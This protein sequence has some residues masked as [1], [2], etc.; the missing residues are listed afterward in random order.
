M[1]RLKQAIIV[2]GKYDK[3]KLE[4]V[5][6]AVILTTEGFGIY[7]DREKLSLI[8]AFAERDGI[9]ILTDS[10][11]AGFQI[12]NFL[13]GSIPNGKIYHAYIPDVFG[14]ETRKEK[15]SKEGKLGVEG[16]SPEVL[17]KALEEAGILSDSGSKSVPAVPA[18]WISLADLMD[19]GLCGGSGSSALR[20]A[21]LKQLGLPERLST[22]SLLE[23][24]NR[25]YEPEEY[26]AALCAALACIK[27]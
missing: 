20:K 2:E 24:L 4:S 5:V 18:P 17:A 3:I 8:R 21:L 12:R 13:R 25:L 27:K 19:D 1:L 26:R 15:P 6:D 10:D 7:K 9:V 11:A 14:K 23:V 16:F 22:K